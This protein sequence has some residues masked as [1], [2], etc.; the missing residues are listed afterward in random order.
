MLHQTV[1]LRAFD[2][3]APALGMLAERGIATAVVSNGDCSLAAALDGAGLRADVVVDSATAGAAKPDPA[4]F[5]IALER[6]GVAAGDA[7][8]VGDGPDTDGAGA[9]AAGIDVVILDRSAQPAGGTIGS[10]A[11]LGRLVA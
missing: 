2:D 7:L 3:A 9:R 11:E 1:V 5:R 8:H 4:I 10:L 6:L